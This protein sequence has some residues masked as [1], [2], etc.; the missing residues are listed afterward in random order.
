MYEKYGNPGKIQS[1]KERVESL[2][3]KWKLRLDR[4]RYVH[5]KVDVRE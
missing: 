4:Q 1:V 2:A 5:R 3:V